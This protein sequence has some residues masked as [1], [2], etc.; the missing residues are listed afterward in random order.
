[1]ARAPKKTRRGITPVIGVI[2]YPHTR[3]SY[4]MS[5]FDRTGYELGDVDRRVQS[6]YPSG[7]L[8]LWSL[9]KWTSGKDKTIPRRDGWPEFTL[10]GIQIVKALPAW[11]PCL[12][13][14]GV[15]YWVSVCRGGSICRAT[16]H[17][18]QEVINSNRQ[19]DPHEIWA[20]ACDF[21]S[22]RSLQHSK[23]NPATETHTEAGL[24]G[25][26]RQDKSGCAG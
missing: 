16:E 21:V 23:R 22:A 14:R 17:E 9:A 20:R 24:Y 4:V 7:R 3:S 8:E 11:I 26:A 6:R 5:M 13:A 15:N 10:A 19:F 25:R 1:M 2:A 18:H 12:K